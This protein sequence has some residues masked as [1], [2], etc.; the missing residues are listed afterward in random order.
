M[1]FHNRR[2]TRRFLHSSVATLILSTTIGGLVI[3]GT[4]G[5]N[6]S[7]AQTTKIVS[8]QQ[9]PRAAG[10]ALQVND[11][12]PKKELSRQELA[13]E[14]R[15]WHTATQEALRRDNPYALRSLTQA[16]SVSVQNDV[17]VVTGDA[18]IITSPKPFD[19]N[20]RATSFLPANNSFAVSTVS[21]LFDNNLGEK[22][23]MTAANNPIPGAEP[24][25]DAYVIEDLGFEFP[26]FTGSYPRVAVSSNG[27][28]VF[29]TGSVDDESFKLGAVSSAPTLSEFQNGFPRIAPY[30]HDLDARAG[31]TTGVA[32]VY[33]RKSF[34]RVMVTWNYIRDYPNNPNV[35]TGLHRFQVTLFATGRITMTFDGA[36]LTSQTLIGISPGNGPGRT[37]QATTMVDLST[38]RGATVFAQAPIAEF[39]STTT[40]VDYISAVNAFYSNLRRDDFD[41]VFFMTDFPYSVGASDE[42]AFYDALRNTDSGI[43][44]DI[45]EVPGA[46]E[47]Y[48][49]SNLQGVLNM[50]SIVDAYPVYPTTRFLGSNH[51]LSVM[52]HELG[53]RWLSFIRFPGD[54]LKLL[55]RQDA[56]WSFFVNSESTMSYPGV[57]R[58]SVMEGNLWKPTADGRYVTAGLVDGYSKLDQY[59]M[60]LLP[61]SEVGSISV[62]DSPSNIS[63]TRVSSPQPNVIA[64]GALNG[65]S[66]ENITSRN[67]ERSAPLKKN[68]RAA[69][70]L[71]VRPGTQPA[72][73]TFEKIKRYRYAFESY[74]EQATN[75]KG[76]IE[77]GFD[78][79]T[80]DRSIA[81]VSAASYKPLLAPGAL[82]SIFGIV[83][84]SLGNRVVEASVVPGTLSLQNIRVT[85]N[86]TP[87]SI[88]A[89]SSGQIN[90]QVPRSITAVTPSLSV[91]S[92]TALAEVYDGNTLIAAGAFQ[93]APSAPML[94]TRLTNDQKEFVAAAFDATTGK[95]EPF[96]GV[97]PNGL[98]TILAVYATGL[99]ADATDV[100]ANVSSE[101]K[102][103]LN[104]TSVLV[105]YAG[106]APGLPGANQINI[107]L[108]TNLGPGDYSLKISRNGVSSQEAK[109]KIR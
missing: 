42:F 97:Q 39:F 72:A 63:Q 8:I 46:T 71:L 74:F 13:E 82:A 3:W 30:W 60:G 12:A 83:K 38:Q 57:E 2:A 67:G 91:N 19:L 94:A 43:G 95:G 4:S 68:F 64:S 108:P 9:S 20:L 15:A 7:A 104:G 41:F 92:A 89:L 80:Q 22:R 61:A 49:S 53:H 44:K 100:A 58:S 6:Q 51:G 32:G 77:T 101:V 109:I 50:N 107:Y 21:S 23:D 98:P 79:Q 84:P 17:A 93:I 48:G 33:V 96:P 47:E 27:S 73:A 54:E 99:G 5:T 105:G 24:G 86:G 26:F 45:G 36:V 16:A 78:P 87:A 14:A 102:A 34:D 106:F 28:L 52:A 31:V 70:V 88:L 59:L 65:Y 35:D 56:H 81:I 40:R 75:T 103:T 76:T 29:P 69:V 37:G 25:D 1:F 66:I 18:N 10:A 85:V 90:F 62:L 55:G 11:P